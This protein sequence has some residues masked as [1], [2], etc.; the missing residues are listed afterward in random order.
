MFCTCITAHN[1]FVP[2]LQL[3]GKSLLQIV[4]SFCKDRDI[5]CHNR[6]HQ[7]ICLFQHCWQRHPKRC[8]KSWVVVLLVW[9][10]LLENQPK[11]NNN[12]DMLWR[13]Q[14][15]QNNSKRKKSQKSVTYQEKDPSFGMTTTQD[16]R[17]LLA[18]CCREEITS[19]ICLF[20]HWISESGILWNPV[21]I[22]V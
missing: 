21:T 12:N 20:Q 10:Q 7:L 2:S 18:W 19:V 17:D 13:A 4:D 6:L 9:H 16:I 3:P 1:L 22:P 11:K 14:Q 15:Q 5:Q 8:L